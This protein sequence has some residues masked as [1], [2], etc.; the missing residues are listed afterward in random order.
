MVSAGR[1]LGVCSSLSEG[2]GCVRSR[3]CIYLNASALPDFSSLRNAQF[4]RPCWK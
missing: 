3:L 1:A 2:R 4:L